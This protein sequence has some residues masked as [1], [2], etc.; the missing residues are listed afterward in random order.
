MDSGRANQTKSSQ[1]NQSL[2]NTFAEQHTHPK[3]PGRKAGAFWAFFGQSRGGFI[4]RGLTK[5]HSGIQTL[6][7]Q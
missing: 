6:P 2:S 5:L 1:H 7:P 4:R 3:S